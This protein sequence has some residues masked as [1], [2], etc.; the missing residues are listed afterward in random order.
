MSLREAGRLPAGDVPGSVVRTTYR[1]KEKP[2]FFG[3]Y[4]LTGELELQSPNT[5][6][7]QAV[8]ATVPNW[9]LR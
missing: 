2:V 8:I 3:H 1:P 7:I 5:G 4:W 6:R 9:R